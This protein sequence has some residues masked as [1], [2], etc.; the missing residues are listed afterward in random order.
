MGGVGDGGGSKVISGRDERDILNGGG[1][2][3]EGVPRKNG[4]NGS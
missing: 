1:G 3:G 4:I 2:G